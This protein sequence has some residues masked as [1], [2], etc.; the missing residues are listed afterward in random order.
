[1]G[2]SVRCL[3]VPEGESFI[4]IFPNA[5]KIFFLR[6]SDRAGDCILTEARA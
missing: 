3:L 4:P 1:M 5:S 2:N 6:Y